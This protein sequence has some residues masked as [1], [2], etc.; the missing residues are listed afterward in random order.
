[1]WARGY[2]CASS[3]NVTDAVI[4]KYI[5]EQ[6]EEGDDHFKVEGGA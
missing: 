2:C 6:G 4:K 5:Q 3:G 1:M